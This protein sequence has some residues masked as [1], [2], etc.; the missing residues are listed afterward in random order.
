M[1]KLEYLNQ[2]R[3]DKISIIEYNQLEQYKK[4]IPEKWFDALYCE[5]FNSRKDNVLMIW[6]SVV[7]EELSNT[8][9]YINDFLVSLDI[10]FDG[11]ECTLIYGINNENG[12]EYYEGR[13]NKNLEINK[14]LSR[15]W[16]NIPSS[17]KRFYDEVHNGFY[18]FA[19]FSMGLIPLEVVICLGE[20][21][22]GI[23]EELTEKPQIS[24]DT[25]FAFFSNEEGLHIVVDANDNDIN[26]AVLW[27]ANREPRYNKNFW[28]Y[29]DELIVM[30]FMDIILI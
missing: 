9:S 14:N 21:D 29:V 22:L 3:K 15:E 24:L 8:I 12:L 19:S 4:Y 18:C 26:N 20:E 1:E 6:D 7:S 2:Y 13:F 11:K 16:N 30:G 10:I 27:F 28:D 25:S 5:D 23:L 17:I